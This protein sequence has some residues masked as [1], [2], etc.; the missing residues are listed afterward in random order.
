[1][2]S[3]QND[4]TIFFRRPISGIMIAAALIALF[5]PM[6][7]KYRAVRRVKQAT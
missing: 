2:F 7:Q 5:L 4:W 6:M 1:M 3:F